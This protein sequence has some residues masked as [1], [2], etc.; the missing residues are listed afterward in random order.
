MSGEYD[1]NNIVCMYEILKGLIKTCS[2]RKNKGKVLLLLKLA[3]HSGLQMIL[4]AS[5]EYMNLLQYLEV[6][7]VTVDPYL[8]K[9]KPRFGLVGCD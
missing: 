9:A 3:Q 6:F 4:P 7:L 1:Q 2:W 8:N 5:W